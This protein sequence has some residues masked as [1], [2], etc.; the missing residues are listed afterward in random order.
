MTPKQPQAK[1]LSAYELM[2]MFPDEQTAVDYLSAILW[3]NGPVCPHCG[4]GQNYPHKSKKFF[5]RCHGCGK[6]FSIR[7]GTIFENSKIPLHKWLY[8]MYLIVTSRKGVSSLQLSKELGITQKSAW[9]LEQRIRAACGNQEVKMLFGFI[10]VDEAY[11]GGLEKNKHNNKKLKKGRG[12]V[13]KTPVFGMRNRLTGRVVAEVVDSTDAATLQGKIK[14][15]VAPGSII[16]TDEHASYNG[17]SASFVHKSVK[18]SAKQFVDG[19]AHTNG[20][21]SVWAVLKRG[22]YGI[23]HSFSQKHMQLYVDEFAFRLNEG[24]CKID[25]VDRLKSLVQGMKGKRLTYG[26]LK[27]G[28]YYRLNPKP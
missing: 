16:F 14:K 18:H 11:L 26:L 12:T 3:P 27:S 13:G 1:V 19:L 2:Q 5:H 20:I 8:A 21:E 22:F 9:F 10:E 24:N 25:T 17:L 15:A 28:N 23:Y 7:V 4:S 6:D